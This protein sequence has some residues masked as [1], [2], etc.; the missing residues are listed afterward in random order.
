MLLTT[1]N[2]QAKTTASHC[3]QLRSGSVLILGRLH[4]NQ[5]HQPSLRRAGVAMAWKRS[6]VRSG[7]R[8][9]KSLDNSYR[10]G[11]A[12][13]AGCHGKAARSEQ[14]I[15]DVT[16]AGLKRLPVRVVHRKM[17]WRPSYASLGMQC[18]VI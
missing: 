8:S 3:L 1:W 4:A 18:G 12:T 10:A 7:Q 6:P 9:T 15:G 11:L 13:T 2:P 14:L 17:R 5:C 16:Q